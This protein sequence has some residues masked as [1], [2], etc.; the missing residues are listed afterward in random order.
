ME[1]RML[2]WLESPEEEMER[3]REERKRERLR[4]QERLDK[5]G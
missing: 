4:L 3:A 1:E 2:R 5:Q